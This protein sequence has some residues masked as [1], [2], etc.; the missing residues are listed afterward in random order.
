MNTPWRPS[1]HGAFGLRSRPLERQADEVVDDLGAH[2]GIVAMV[3]LQPTRERRGALFPVLA[4]QAARKRLG[5]WM[6]ACAVGLESC[7]IRP[8]HPAGEAL[9]HHDQDGRPPYARAG[10]GLA[11]SYRRHAGTAPI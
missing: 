7:R 11:N 8:C 9:Q 10:N 2:V 3:R 5:T 6:T 4:L 1:S